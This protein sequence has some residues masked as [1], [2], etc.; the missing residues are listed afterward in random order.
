MKEKTTTNAFKT[1]KKINQKG[2]PLIGLLWSMKKDPLKFFTEISRDYGEVVPL[3]LGLETI[4]FIN[5]PEH[6]KRIF[7][8]NRENYIRSKYYGQLSP[9][10]GDGLFT[11]EGKAWRKQRKTTQPAMSGPNLQKMISH[12][13]AATQEQIDKFG[14]YAAKDQAF[15][16]TIEAF[17]LKLEIVM[18]ALFSTRLNQDNFKTVLNSLTIILKEI[19][20]RIWE[21]FPT[22]LWMATKRNIK[23]R[24]A[25]SALREIISNVIMERLNKKASSDD[26]LNT[27]IEAEK[28]CGWDENSHDSIRDQVIS[29]AI[30]GHETGA[31]SLCWLA[32]TLSKNPEIARKIRQEANEVIASKTPDY[33]TFQNL[34]YTQKVFKEILRLYPPLWT[35]SRQA[36]E[37]DFLGQQKIPKGAIVMISPYT[38]HRHPKFWKN[39]EGFDPERFTE[40][41]ENARHKFAYFPFGG[42]PHLCLGNRF[43]MIDGVLSLA[44]ICQK[45]DFELVTGQKIFPIPMT[46]LRPNGPMLIKV[47]REL[48]TKLRIAA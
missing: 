31:I 18:R 41:N 44:M 2:M 39:P 42:G 4:Y 12:M 38:I 40:E 20:T 1:A 47:R 46:T 45:F 6:L 23:L 5:H 10:I 24:R 43:G 25:I 37:E 21:I 48:E 19:E 28:A 27:L 16:I 9:I 34:K 7:Q 29:I 35:V 17:H 26:L 8:D 30:A 32:Y 36:K 33:Q 11:L 3:R 22:P 14:V 15:D 13:V